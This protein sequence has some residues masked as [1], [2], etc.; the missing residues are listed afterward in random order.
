MI[1]HTTKIQLRFSDFDVLR[2]VNNAKYATFM[3][4]ARVDYFSEIIAPGHNWEETGILIAR[5]EFD[6]KIPVLMTDALIVETHISSIGTKSIVFDHD[7]IVIGDAGPILKAKGKSVTVCYHYAKQISMPV[8][9]HW[10]QR[11]NDFQKTT[12]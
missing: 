6:F 7:F 2:H 10:R 8:P 4:N 1:V 9:E 12:H 11:I 3:E 5:L